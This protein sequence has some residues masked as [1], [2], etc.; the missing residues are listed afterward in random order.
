M[1]ARLMGDAIL[2]FFGA[3]L[4]HEDDPERAILAA[5]DILAGLQPF[6]ERVR[7]ETGLDF[8]VRVGINTGPVVVGDIG[9][10]VR[11]E[12]TAM[13]DAVNLAAR[14]QAA[15]DPGTV[16]IA[17]STYRL[18]APLFDCQSLGEILVKGK[19]EPVPAYRVLGRKAQPGRLR[20]VP[21]LYSPLIGREG[22][23]CP[24]L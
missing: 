7:R 24:G 22:D 16:Q 9:S 18:V 19:S 5:L 14:M 2:A 8:N 3:P 12:Y 21:G 4:A 17:E 1:V 15:A 10:Q 6:G 13:G 20:G 11:M 23:G